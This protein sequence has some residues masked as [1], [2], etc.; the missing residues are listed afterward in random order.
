[1]TFKEAMHKKLTEHGM[2]DNQASKVLEECM[3]HEST[4]SMESR[5][6]HDVRNYPEGIQ[7]SLW[8][9][10]RSRAAEWIKRNIPKA[11][12]RPM[13]EDNVS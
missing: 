13:F 7:I 9:I 12:F 11:W 1:M 5:W 3:Q 2:F 10:V 8:L 4:E 6:D